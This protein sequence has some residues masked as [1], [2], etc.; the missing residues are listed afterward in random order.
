MVLVYEHRSATAAAGVMPKHRIFGWGATLRTDALQK[1][2]QFAAQHPTRMKIDIG[3]QWGAV[4]ESWAFPAERGSRAAV[5]GVTCALGLFHGKCV[6]LALFAR[7]D[8]PAII[9]VKLAESK[10]AGRNLGRPQSAR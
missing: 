2:Q 1:L 4:V 10:R 3:G 7:S 5:A 8:T 9:R 6:G